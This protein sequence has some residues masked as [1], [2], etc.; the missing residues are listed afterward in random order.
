VSTIVLERRRSGRTRA[1]GNPSVARPGLPLVAWITLVGAG[2]VLVQLLNE[3]RAGVGLASPPLRAWF[4]P[5]VPPFIV[6]P[7]LVA[8]LVITT[9]PRLAARLRWGPFVGGAV[10]AAAAW[11]AALSSVRG[12]DRLVAPIRDPNEYRAVAQHVQSVG[13]FVAG[14]VGHVPEY[15]VHV[16]GHPPGPVLVEWTLRQ[17]G[18]GTTW[19]VAGL[20]IVGGASA[21]GAVLVAARE[22]AGEPWA[23]RAAPFAVLAPVAIWVATSAD[24]LFAGVAAWGS[25]LVIVATGRSDRRGEVAALVGGL[26]LGWTAFSS[27]GLVLIG[28][29]P[30]AVAMRRR[31]IRPLLIAALGSAAVGLSFAW[32]GFSWIAGLVATRARYMDGIA[33]RRP[34]AVFLIANVSALAI[35]VGPATAVALRRLRT[36][37]IWVL[38]GAALAAVTVA[39]LSGMSKGEVE[40]IWLPFTPWILLAG[41]AFTWRSEGIPWS[42]STLRS[43]ATAWLTLQAGTAIAIESFV[44]TPW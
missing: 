7:A 43:P 23:R 16:A 41:A 25:A 30:L 11:A 36:A 6:V 27:Y 44:R 38:V 40:R 13:G 31:R 34:Y 3:Q 26:L 5:T 39:D 15:P 10:G 1:D 22:V 8:V 9:G 33:S 32:A 20:F 14:F 4:D 12:V 28:L 42:R 35:V 17:L 2:A 21:V 37:G 19:S 24:A 18:L 29:I